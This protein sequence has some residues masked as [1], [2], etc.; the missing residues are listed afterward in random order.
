[1]RTLWSAG[2]ALSAVELGRLALS[3]AH[4]SFRLSWELR[5]DLLPDSIASAIQGCTGHPCC[6]IA[7]TY[8][9]LTPTDA[10]VYSV[11]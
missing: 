7:R 10:E 9:A 5:A 3:G 4:L 2:A 6:N 1:M 11:S 8:N